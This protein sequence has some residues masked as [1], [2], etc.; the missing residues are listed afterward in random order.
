MHRVARNQCMRGEPFQPPPRLTWV[1]YGRITIHV[2]A[3]LVLHEKR[4]VEGGGRI[5]V[6]AIEVWEVPRSG[7]YPTGRKFRLFFVVDGTVLIGF[8]NH[9]PKGPH[10]H[11]RSKEVPYAFTAIDRLVNDFWDLVRKAGFSP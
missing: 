5:G 6:A 7:D 1:I 3:N 8:D 9:R 2:K 11:L 4:L 10:L